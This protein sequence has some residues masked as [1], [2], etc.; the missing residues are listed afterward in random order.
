M[1]NLLH[2]G[3]KTQTIRKTANGFYMITKLNYNSGFNNHHASEAIKGALPLDQNNPQNCPYSLYAEQLSG[4]AFTQNREKNRHSWLYR[5]LPS[6][7]KPDY[8]KSQY[9]FNLQID[10][11]QPPTPLRFDPIPIGNTK[12]NFIKGLNFICKQNTA[13]I[14]CYTIN[15]ASSNEYFINH[16]GEYL[17]IPEIGNILFHTEFGKLVLS[18]GEILVIPRGII[19]KLELIEE[20]A[21][22]FLC[23]NKG[24]PFELPQ[25]GIIG[26]NGLANPRHFQYPIAC[27][28]KDKIHCQLISKYLDNLWDVNLQD[29]PLNVVAWHGNYAPYKYALR[30]FN[31]L[32]TVSFDH[33]DP[34][35][36][37]VLSS[38]SYESNVSNLDFVI[39]P[40]RWTV[41]EHSL[42]LPYF[43]RNIMSE[44]MGLLKG[45]YDAKKEGFKPGSY[46]I[47]NCMVNHGPDK[48]SYEV[49]I[50]QTLKPEKYENTL[51]FMLESKEP[52]LV[53]KGS[54]SLTTRQQDY[55]QCWQGFKSA[56]I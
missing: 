22:G 5:I 18:P 8:T 45:E 14:F 10:N 51:A 33:P 47:H 29:S 11:N 38:P 50:K 7:A 15:H 34:S 23:E 25:H 2:I 46:S 26:A 13:T 6:V 28:E 36:F 1:D 53:A 27:F 39:F 31:T 32:N 54:L 55:S 52:W 21:R 56:D 35:I 41:A 19:F 17:F 3:Y 48:N 49:A 16:D 24:L 44:F 30:H 42:R 43:H 40:E 37:T 12:L 9:Q 20:K 4:S